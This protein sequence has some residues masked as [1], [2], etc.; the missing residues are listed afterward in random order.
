MDNTTINIMLCKQLDPLKM[1][2]HL[3]HLIKNQPDNTLLD[4][5]GGWYYYNNNEF[6]NL[7]TNRKQELNDMTCTNSWISKEDISKIAEPLV[8]DTHDNGGRPFRVTVCHDKIVVCVNIYDDINEYAS[9]DIFLN[10]KLVLLGNEVVIEVT[11]FIGLWTGFDSSVYNQPGN[12]ILIK[13]RTNEYIHISDSIKR[14][15]TDDEIYDYI[16]IMGNNDVSYPLAYGNNNIYLL[17][18]DYCVDKKNVQYYY[19]IANASDF[20]TYTFDQTMP[21]NSEVICERDS[22]NGMTLRDMFNML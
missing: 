19:S 7:E 18:W 10:S 22:S 21:L 16:A 3:L 5:C 12:S 20:I 13:I 2:H 15:V 17:C 11:D 6:I 1:K 14:F 4:P 8:F 9:I